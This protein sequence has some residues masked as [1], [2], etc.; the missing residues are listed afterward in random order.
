MS[1][2][3]DRMTADAYLALDDRRRT[4]LIHGLIVVNEPTWPHQRV[5]GLVHQAL[6]TWKQA[7]QG[8]GEVCLPLD[9]V[10][11]LWLVDLA[12]RTMLVYRRGVR[13]SVFD[14]DVEI[15][16]GEQLESP[17]L[18]GFSARV[19]ELIPQPPARTSPAS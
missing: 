8:R 17:L 14:L 15:T 9:G 16:A 4:E 2:L 19:G 11:E 18:P 3:A 1:T 10:R 13:S 6:I 7:A 12:S 5:V